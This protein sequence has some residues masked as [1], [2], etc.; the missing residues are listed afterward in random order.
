MATTI[1]NF[2]A[3]DDTEVDAESP[4]TE[5]LVTRLRD[6]SYWIDAGTR[7]TT[8]TSQ[9]KVLVPDG[10]GGV[11]WVEANTVSGVNG[12]KGNGSIGTSSGAPTQIAEVTSGTLMVWFA[13]GNTT[14]SE[15]SHAHIIITQSDDTFVLSSSSEGL[16]AGTTISA[17]GTLTGSFAASLFGDQSGSA[18]S[19][20]Y[21]KS[22]SNYEFYSPKGDTFQ[23]LWL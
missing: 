11:E 2:S 9:T 18:N 23:Y 10:S 13:D 3:I 15:V 22:G 5:T 7:K 1:G 17:S 14:A 8:Q 4:I 20:F 19:L 21:R 12:T 6:N 16:G